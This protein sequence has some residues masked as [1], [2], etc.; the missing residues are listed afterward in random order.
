MTVR[1][2]EVSSGKEVEKFHFDNWVL[3]VAFSPDGNLLVAATDGEVRV[4][5]R[6]R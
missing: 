4:W 3:V 1:L 6:V 2:W 5:K